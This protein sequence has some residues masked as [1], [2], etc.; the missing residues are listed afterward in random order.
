MENYV[1]ISSFR[2]FNNQTLVTLI[3]PDRKMQLV[4]NRG[5]E[6]KTYTFFPT[7]DAN[8]ENNLVP[9]AEPR[10]FMTQT[11]CD[12]DDSFLFNVESSDFEN[13]DNPTLLNVYSVDI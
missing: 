6:S 12:S 2:T 10:A 8:L 4:V 1:S 13:E 3:T 11:A 5:K 9:H 7:D